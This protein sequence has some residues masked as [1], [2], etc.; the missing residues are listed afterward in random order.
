MIIID[1]YPVKT[2]DCRQWLKCNGTQGNAVPPPPISESKR[3]PTSDC[4]NDRKRHTTTDRDPNLNVSFPHHKFCTLTTDCRR[5]F[6]PAIIMLRRFSISNSQGNSKFQEYLPQETRIA[7]PHCIR[8]CSSIA[9]VGLVGGSFVGSAL[10]ATQHTVLVVIML[11]ARAGRRDLDAADYLNQLL[12]A[13][14]CFEPWSDL[15]RPV[16]AFAIAASYNGPTSC[17]CLWETQSST[18]VDMYVVHIYT[19]QTVL[20]IKIRVHYIHLYSPFLV[21]K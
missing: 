2:V 6:R 3:S 18:R 11:A 8:G 5:L 1:E 21:D 13:G 19:V 20:S 10:S 14:Y 7:G 9:R 17:V 4:Y 15:L 12:D 16:A